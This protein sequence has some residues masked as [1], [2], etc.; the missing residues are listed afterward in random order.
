MSISTQFRIASVVLIAAMSFCRPMIGYGQE[1]V[2]ALDRTLSE[3]SHAPRGNAH[4]VFEHC[5]PRIRS[6]DDSVRESVLLRESG[7]LEP[8][9]QCD[10]REYREGPRQG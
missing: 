7:D 9:L 3:D 5:R 10:I 6:N 1:V 4:H 8:V 2:T